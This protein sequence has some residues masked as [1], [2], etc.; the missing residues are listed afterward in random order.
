M[1]RIAPVT[2]VL[3][4]LLASVVGCG[5]IVVVESTGGSSSSATTSVSSSV[6]GNG[7]TPSSSS[8]ASSTGGNGGSGGAGGVSCVPVD[9][10]NLCTED[11][12]ENDL[13]V[14]EPI[15]DGTNCS[16]GDV[17]TQTDTCHTGVCVGGDPVLCSGAAS[18]V[19]GACVGP[20]CA[21]LFGDPKPPQWT[22]GSH[23]SFVAAA[24]LNGDGA[25]DLVVGTGGFGD[26][27]VSVLVNSGEGT[28]TIAASSARQKFDHISTIPGR[29]W[30]GREADTG[31]GAQP[32]LNRLVSRR[33][34]CPRSGARSLANPGQTSGARN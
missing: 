11:L 33:R 6:G 9:D 21:G 27:K 3:L 5:S 12:C 13:A 26:S 4:P 29:N 10:D 20:G 14:H 31:F 25:P 32:Q 34:S 18:C 17:C 16:D 8:E 24:D 30:G 22:G 15:A 23:P 1:S 28:F 7:G 2:A 19:A